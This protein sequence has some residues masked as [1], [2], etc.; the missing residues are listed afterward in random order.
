MGRG[1]PKQKTEKGDFHQKVNK[2]KS[3]EH[4]GMIS[5]PAGLATATTKS[6]KL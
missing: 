5:F 1:K 4:M 3:Q 6:K 2:N